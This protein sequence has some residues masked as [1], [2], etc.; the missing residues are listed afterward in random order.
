MN[1]HADNSA[2]Q[3]VTSRLRIFSVTP[4]QA[5][6]LIGSL[7]K[8][9]EVAAL[10]PWM[11][12]KTARE[13]GQESLRIELL[14]AAGSL[15]VWAIQRLEDQVLLGAMLDSPSHAGSNVE[16][17]LGRDYWGLGIADEALEPILDWM[18]S[19]EQLDIELPPAHT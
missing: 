13:V 6:R 10:V 1:E 14:S 7:L 5:S 12:G 2:P 11:N 4:R 15:T 19:I 17:I 8:D 3:F 9:P 16:V 18:R